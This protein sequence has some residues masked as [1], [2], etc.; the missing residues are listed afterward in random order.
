MMGEEILNERKV[1]IIKTGCLLINDTGK[2]LSA[3]SLVLPRV[4]LVRFS[5]RQSA[6][7]IR[8]HQAIGIHCPSL[9]NFY[10]RLQWLSNSFNDELASRKKLRNLTN[11]WKVHAAPALGKGWTEI[12]H[13][14][15]KTTSGIALP[16][17]EPVP[18]WDRLIWGDN[19]IP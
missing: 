7:W 12:K 16:R 19:K 5:N 10:V 18:G 15:L 9:R 1:G 17:T 6:S 2:I 13:V 8:S 3:F 4:A 11:Q 14:A